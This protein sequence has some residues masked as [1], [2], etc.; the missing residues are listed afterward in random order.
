MS[1]DESLRQTTARVGD[2]IQTNSNE[3]YLLCVKD[4]KFYLQSFNGFKQYHK[5]ESIDELLMHFE[6]HNG[7][8]TRFPVEYFALKVVNK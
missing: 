2:V 1:L 4:K 6:A 7:E 8:L 5:Y 3:Y